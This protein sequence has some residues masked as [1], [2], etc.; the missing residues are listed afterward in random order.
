[1]ISVKEKKER[2]LG[3]KL[4]LKGERCNS[5][6]CVTV[7]RPYRPGI[8]GQGRH[9]LTDYGRQLQEKQKIK[10]Y[11]GLNNN[12]MMKLFKEPKAKIMSVL[13]RRLDHV[14]FLLG[15]VRSGRIARQM[16][17]HGHIM[18]NNHKVTIPSFSV[19]I[20]NVIT[21]RPES[22]GMKIFEDLGLRLK[23]Y[24][25]PAWLKLDKE[26]LKGECASEPDFQANIFPFDIDLVGQFYSR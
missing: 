2:S 13:E 8:H 21:I 7:R 5:P 12:Q 15:F 3:V 4:F 9:S 22:S 14:I 11:Y 6:K 18:V 17:S 24:E 23:Q 19:K 25:P 26:K 20:G 1:M 16:V 10:I